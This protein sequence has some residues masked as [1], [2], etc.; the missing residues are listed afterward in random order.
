MSE[1]F[2]RAKIGRFGRDSLLESKEFF[3]D[4]ESEERRNATRGLQLPPVA[5]LNNGYSDK[6]CSAFPDFAI[7]PDPA[8]MLINDNVETENWRGDLISCATWL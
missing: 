7:K 1:M 2:Y 6:A 3:L 4:S 8:L 5:L